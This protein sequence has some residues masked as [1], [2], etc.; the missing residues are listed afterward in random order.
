MIESATIASEAEAFSIL[1]LPGAGRCET[2]IPFGN[3]NKKGG[4]LEAWV[5]AK[6][7]MPGSLNQLPL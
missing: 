6:S 7:P 1:G 4:Y 3:D 5:R 2:Q